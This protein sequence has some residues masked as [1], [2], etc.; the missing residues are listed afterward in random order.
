MDDVSDPVG[1]C[2]AP[3]NPGLVA[4]LSGNEA[5]FALDTDSAS[6]VDVDLARDS[7]PAA[8]PIAEGIKLNLAFSGEVGAEVVEVSVELVGLVGCDRN[9][10]G[11][12]ADGSVSS[13]QTSSRLTT[14][15]LLTVGGIEI[16]NSLASP[17]FD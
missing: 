16:E 2:F 10:F 7:R 6:D 4:S 3:F 17:T 15:A 9:G 12:I 14:S 8:Y 5:A 11:D 1:S 13:G